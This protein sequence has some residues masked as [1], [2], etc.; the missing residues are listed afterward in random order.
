MFDKS[1][2]YGVS[3]DTECK[4]HD[5]IL[6]EEKIAEKTDNKYKIIIF[7][8]IN[9]T[10]NYAKNIK[11]EE[12]KKPIIIIA[13]EQ[14]EGRGRLGK[15]FFSPKDTGLYMSIVF[16]PDK[17][18]EELFMLTI[19]AAVS[20]CEAVINITELPAEIKWVNDVFI[21]GKKICGILT[22]AEINYQSGKIEKAIVGIGV[23]TQ[24]PENNFPKEIENIA[25]AINSEKA[26]RNILAAEIINKFEEYYQEN[27][28][29]SIIEKYKKYSLVLNKKIR[30]IKNNTEYSATATDI[31]ERGN[32]VVT[33]SDGT[34]DILN[35]G[36][37]SIIPTE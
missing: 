11:K 22:E 4:M 15:T 12:I 16:S 36:E 31:N 9:S 8:K 30:Y 35:S 5:D 32:L 6:S 33:L 29:K 14:T 34:T 13:N 23:N 21:D 7:D 1:Q 27:D 37:I 17:S 10:N 26:E 28:N 18:P 3:S 19:I 25:S 24:F 2:D 20:V